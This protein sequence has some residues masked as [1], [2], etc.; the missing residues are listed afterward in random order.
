MGFAGARASGS[1]ILFA[2]L[3]GLLNGRR[4]I[5]LDA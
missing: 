3:A 4:R 1:T 5:H 2:V